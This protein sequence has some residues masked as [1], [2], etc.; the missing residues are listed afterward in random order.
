MRVLPASVPKVPMLPVVAL[1]ASLQVADTKPKPVIGISV[2]VT[3]S[4]S[5]LTLMATGETGTSVSAAVVVT[6][7]GVDAKLVCVNVNGPPKPPIVV[8]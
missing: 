3:F 5:E 2:I 4:F 6:E 8:F 7:S 1:F